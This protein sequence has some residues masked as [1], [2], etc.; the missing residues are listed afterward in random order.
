MYPIASISDRSLQQFRTS[1]GR[2]V[3]AR[4]GLSPSIKPSTGAR[5]RTMETSDGICR[6]HTAPSSVQVNRTHNQTPTIEEGPV[7]TSTWGGKGTHLGVP[8]CAHDDMLAAPK[9]VFVH[10]VVQR[11]AMPARDEPA[12]LLRDDRPRANVP[13]PVTPTPSNKSVESHDSTRGGTYQQPI[14]QYKSSPPCATIA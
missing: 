8:N 4:Q 10:I 3:S 6:Q 7:G 14:S 12:R 11:R 9:H 2:Y 5:T 13:W 1:L